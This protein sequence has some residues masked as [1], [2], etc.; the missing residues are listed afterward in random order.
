MVLPGAEQRMKYKVL[1]WL[2][3]V[4]FCTVRKYWIHSN[5]DPLTATELNTFK[6]LR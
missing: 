5:V 6:W 4:K 2:Q 3:S 1:E